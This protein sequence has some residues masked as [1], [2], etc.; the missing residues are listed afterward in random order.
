MKKDS[1]KKRVRYAVMRTDQTIPAF[2]GDTLDA[3]TA[4]VVA[5]VR[6]ELPSRAT[7]NL[8]YGYYIAEVA[9]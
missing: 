5:N 4:V 6:G 8:N 1:K 7:Y 3:A 9:S 2:V